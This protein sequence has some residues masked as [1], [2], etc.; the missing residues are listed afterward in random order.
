[1]RY[2]AMIEAG[3]TDAPVIFTDWDPKRSREFTIKDNLPAGSWDWEMLANEWDAAELE[4]W[5]LE[6]P[7]S[8]E[9]ETK[10]L[11]VIV[12]VEDE[13][14]AEKLYNEMTDRGYKTRV[15]G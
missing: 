10:P 1:M 15:R 13:A 6:I 9:D 8:G 14:D 3:W 7:G 5:G 2:H 12:T 11:S 4:D